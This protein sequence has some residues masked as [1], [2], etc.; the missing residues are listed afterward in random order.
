MSTYSKHT[1][2]IRRLDKLGRVVIPR[3]FR[4]LHKIKFTDPLEIICHDNGDI[5]VRKFDLTS[6]L[7]T[8]GQPVADELFNT[9]NHTILLCDANKVVYASGSTK[10]VPVG[11]KLDLKTQSMIQER[12]CFSGKA[13]EL[14]IDGAEYATLC[15]IFGEDVFGGFI[16]VSDNPTT[17]W[18]AKTLQMAAR[19]LG[20]TMQKF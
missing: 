19:I 12:K 2:I 14:G 20:N 4:K 17:D 7:V 8:T 18:D 13:G 10:V 1:G 9:L 5:I 6:Q 3:E 16:I 11:T 15:T